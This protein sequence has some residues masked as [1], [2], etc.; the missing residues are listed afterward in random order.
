MNSLRERKEAF[1]TGHEGTTLMEIN[2]ATLTVP[3]GMLLATHLARL[4]GQ[5]TTII[6]HCL[7]HSLDAAGLFLPS[8][9]VFLDAAN[10]SSVVGLLV[11]LNVIAAAVLSRSPDAAR[12]RRRQQ[13]QVAAA[14]AQPHKPFVATW[15]GTMTLTTCACILAVDFAAFPRRFAKA[16]TFGTGLM[17]VGVG[18]FVLANAVPSKEARG[19]A[20]PDWWDH[21]CCSLR[22]VCPLLTLGAAR[23]LA[24]SAFSYQVHV[25]EYGVHWNFFFSLAV[26]AMLS[27]AV[28]VP[29]RWRWAVGAGVLLCHQTALSCT[30]LGAY[31]ASPDRGQDLMSLNKE[32]IISSVGMW[33]LYMTGTELGHTIFSSS[34]K[35]CGAAN[36]KTP[37]IAS[38]RRWALQLWAVDA[39]LWSLLWLSV[40]FIEPVSRRRDEYQGPLCIWDFSQ[41][42]RYQLAQ[43]ECAHRTRE[44]VCQH[45]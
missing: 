31:V 36:G 13:T 12:E 16:E 21:L 15:R 45:T 27:S 40:T 32:G 25:G 41:R 29:A 42:V 9:A 4:Y 2:A 14:L 33:G 20:P 44:H 17:D 24:T 38:W 1:V 6:H 19:V 43:G 39:G 5:P 3:L 7:A 35:L 30:A 34:S 22:S 37:S 28:R 23:L 26:V 8:M 18:S 10:A 11:I